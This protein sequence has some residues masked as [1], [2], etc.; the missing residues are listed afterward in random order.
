MTRL[1][2]AIGLI[3]YKQFEQKIEDHCGPQM[4]FSC[5]DL[6][7]RK[8]GIDFSAHWQHFID[9]EIEPCVDHKPTFFV[10]FLDQPFIVGQIQFQAP[11]YQ[12]PPE[13]QSTRYQSEVLTNPTW[14]D[15]CQCFTD[16][17]NYHNLVNHRFLENVAIS[18]KTDDVHIAEFI[19]GS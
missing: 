14:L 8:V 17:M 19:T 11:S 5:F 10:D 16:F 4:V 7:E 12:V 13:G 18:R 1:Y 6:V 9:N 15:M 2:E 3:T